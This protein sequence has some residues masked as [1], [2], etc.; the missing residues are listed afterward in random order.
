MHEADQQ[1]LADTGL[2]EKEEGRKTTARGGWARKEPLDLRSK[3]QHEG[4][5]SDQARQAAHQWSDS[6][7]G[8]GIRQTPFRRSSTPSNALSDIARGWLT[9]RNSPSDH[10][11]GLAR[12]LRGV[13]ATATSYRAGPPDP[14]RTASHRAAGSR[15]PPDH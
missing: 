4:A 13:A 12:H 5:V 8:S 9:R 11:P 2:A 3:R 7:Q 15:P 6:S 10:T 14:A 1:P